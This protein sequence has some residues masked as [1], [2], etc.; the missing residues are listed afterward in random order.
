MIH[1]DSVM[2]LLLMVGRYLLPIMIHRDSVMILL[3]M[4]GRYLLPDNDT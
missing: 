1:R 4:V 3:L 2:I